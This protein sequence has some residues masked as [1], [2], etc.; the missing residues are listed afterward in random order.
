MP[1]MYEL[2]TI[3]SYRI[4]ILTNGMLVEP[5]E[6]DSPIFP[7]FETIAEATA[8]IIARQYYDDCIILPIT[9]LIHKYPHA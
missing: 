5:T 4:Y 6:Y 7:D 3:T 1:T 8:A 9:S 2:V